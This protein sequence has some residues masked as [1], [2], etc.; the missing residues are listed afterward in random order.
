MVTA[1]SAYKTAF[2][3]CDSHGSELAQLKKA[4]NWWSKGIGLLGTRNIPVGV[5]L[6]LPGISS[7]HT[8]FMLFPI[9]VIF[10][11]QSYRVL[12]TERMVRPGRLTI[13]CSKARHTIELRGGTLDENKPNI[14]ERLQ[15]RAKGTNKGY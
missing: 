8:V 12:K 6:W 1:A 11:D 2:L 14:D 4:A 9:D 15:I 3:L 7:I 13:Q 5:G 10:L